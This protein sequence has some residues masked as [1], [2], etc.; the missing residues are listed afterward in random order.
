MDY[1]SLIEIVRTSIF[2]EDVRSGIVDSIGSMKGR[3]IYVGE[4]GLETAD[5]L[6]QKSMDDLMAIRRSLELSEPYKSS[7]KEK[8]DQ[9][10]SVYGFLLNLD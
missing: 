5:E 6:S 2:G 10:I 3:V 1:D 8:Y 9:L 7:T 4:Y